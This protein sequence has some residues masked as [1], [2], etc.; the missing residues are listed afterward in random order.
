MKKI[1]EETS[2]LRNIHVEG[3][4]NYKPVS[5]L[6]LEMECLEIAP[7]V[8]GRIKILDETR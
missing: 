5:I 8:E 6:E 4:L 2:S 3:G 1:G 7:E